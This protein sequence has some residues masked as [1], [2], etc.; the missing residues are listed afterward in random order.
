M[1]SGKISHSSLRSYA[2]SLGRAYDCSTGRVSG[3]KFESVQLDPSLDPRGF[4]VRECCNSEEHPNTVPVILALDVTGS[5]GE[6]CS[7]TAAALGKIVTSLF[8]KFNDIEFCIM[9]IG[10]LDY[11][12]AP[13]QMSQFESDVRIAVALDKVYME[14]GGGGNGFESYTA[15]WYMGLKR[16]KLDAYDKQ[17]RKGI[18]ITMGDEPLNPYLPC[19]HLNH[20]INGNEERDIETK[21]LYAAASQ[22][23]DIFH[24]AVDSPECCYDHYKKDVDNSFGQQLGSRYK[25]STIDCL[26][27]TI[28]DCIAESING[29]QL[30]SATQSNNSD[31]IKW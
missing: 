16:T 7:E 8:E 12:D 19:K 20:C 14:H 9:G 30:S 31:G 26:A 15:A 5:M 6:A 13:I 10:D 11:D 22:K 2:S 28:E 3:Q 29:M 23:F 21:E 27:Q 17:G 24:I 25:V 4:K 1:G 18:I